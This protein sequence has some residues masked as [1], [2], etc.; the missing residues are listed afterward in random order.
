MLRPATPLAILVSIAFV[1]LL[2]SVLSTP[3]I[4]AIPLAT[5]KSVDFGAFG[6]CKPQ[7]D[8]TNIKV[9]Y[10]TGIS[11]WS[12][13]LCSQK[14][15]DRLANIDHS[16]DSASLFGNNDS[17]DFS[18]PAG[19]R[20]SL[21]SILI[22][23]PIA[24][25]FAL[26]C[27]SLAIG[28]H[29]HS[30]SHSPR[31]LLALLL[32]LFLTVLI[33]LL[34]FLVDIL[35]FVPRLSWGGW[36]VL[37]ATIL[38]TAGAIVTCG[39]RRMLVSRKARK[40]RI[41]ENAEMNGENF[42]NRQAAAP[43]PQ[44]PPTVGARAE[45]P[46]P[47]PHD[48]APMVNGAQGANKLPEFAMF[49][50]ENS[51]SIEDDRIPLKS[52]TP[53]NKTVPGSGFS[54]DS[55]VDEYQRFGPPGRGNFR[56]RGARGG[57]YGMT[58]DEYGSSLPPSNGYG[59]PPRQYSDK[60]GFSQGARGRGRGGYPPVAYGRGG[61]MRPMRGGP[62]MSSGYGR[63]ASP[64]SIGAMGGPVPG[65]NRSNPP[66]GYV[67]EYEQQR[68]MDGP[69]DQKRPLD[70]DLSYPR[71][72]SAPGY[73]RRPSPG[74]PSAPGAYGRRPSPGAP[75]APGG[76]GRQPSPGPPSAPGGYGRR[77]SPGP[78]SAPGAYG[79]GPSPGPP[80]AGGYGRGPSPGPPQAQG[81]Y[82]N[83]PR[84]PSPRL[85]GFQQHRSITP[86]PPLPTTYAREGEVIGQAIEMDAHT[87]SP[88]PVLGQGLQSP[89]Q[90]IDGVIAGPPNA[91]RQGHRESP[92]SLT[93][94]YS[95]QG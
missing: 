8:C 5:F 86:P 3:I 54:S 40:K 51:K 45:S 14:I 78:P 15:W 80:L 72:Q 46:P 11:P 23:H 84:Q 49:E 61:P 53:S 25:L 83:A 65:R 26:I 13:R 66:P 9:G 6:Y 17:D 71:D 47:L 62:G 94:V 39:M 95:I 19:A 38:M 82:G 29:F 74:L 75:S 48:G 50:R 33:S 28:A 35:L 91:D 18:L 87:G 36:I 88:S 60:S 16:K 77:P 21:S 32:L 92:L 52:R 30:P 85:A 64:A 58:R 41:A 7:N 89:P 42:Y 68:G 90:E 1:L 12:S 34:A 44:S 31:Y 59:P 27:F 63:D 69:Y 56:G 76:Y 22:V 2:L 4:K 67:N 79:R 57:G 55:P 81:G 93:S 10:A 73:A 70:D 20:S 43:L 24:A 37:A